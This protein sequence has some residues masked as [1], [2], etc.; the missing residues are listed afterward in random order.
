VADVASGAKAGIT[1]F[2]WA[3][4]LLV[5]FVLPAVLCAVL[6]ALFRKKGWIKDGDLKLD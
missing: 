1:A 3:G 5:S 4:L 2:D 6:G